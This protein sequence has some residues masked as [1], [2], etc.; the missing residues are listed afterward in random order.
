MS[1]KFYGSFHNS[2]LLFSWEKKKKVFFIVAHKEKNSEV[3]AKC[4]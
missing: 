4:K 3:V 2:L 1:D